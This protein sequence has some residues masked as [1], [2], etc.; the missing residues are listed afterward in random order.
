M[1][2]PSRCPIAPFTVWHGSRRLD[3]S[4]SSV[5]WLRPATCCPRVSHGHGPTV[6]LH[7]EIGSAC[8][9]LCSVSQDPQRGGAAA[10]GVERRMWNL[11]GYTGRTPASPARAVGPRTCDPPAMRVGPITF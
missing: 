9:L 5:G 2:L 1:T 6:A 7:R 10:R 3:D 4:N 8:P 11:V